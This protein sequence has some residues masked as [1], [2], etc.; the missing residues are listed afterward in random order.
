MSVGAD[1]LYGAK[2]IAAYA[3]GDVR[4]ATRVYDL[5]RRSRPP[6]R[7]PMF[8]MAGTLCARRSSIDDWYET[9][10]AAD[11]DNHAPAANETE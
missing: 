10:E 6:H 2:E 5:H 1:V 3:F 4:H 9:R 11:N 7:F 8:T